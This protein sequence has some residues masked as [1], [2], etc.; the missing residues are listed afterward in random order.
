MGKLFRFLFGLVILA[1]LLV[2]LAGVFIYFYFDPN[3]YK[4]QIVDKVK[5]QTGRE[6]AINQDMSLLFFPSLAIRLADVELKQ[7]P[8]FGKGTFAKVDELSVS[9]KI[10]PLFSKQL[11]ID[12]II[13][14]GLELDL[15]K[16]KKGVTNWSDLSANKREKPPEAPKENTEKPAFALEKIEI[17]GLQLKNAQIHWDD[18]QQ[19]QKVDIQD[20]NLSLGQIIPNQIIPLEFKGKVQVNKPNIKT[21]L[22][23]QGDF[24]FN[25]EYTHF[26]LNNSVIQVNAKGDVIPAKK[27]ILDLNA[28]IDYDL[29]KALAKLAQIELKIATQGAK[30]IP[31]DALTI[32]LKT[33]SIQYDV[34]Q[35]SAK[36]PAFTLNID[37][38]KTNH[39][40]M[41]PFKKINWDIKGNSIQYQNQ[42]AIVKQLHAKLKADGIDQK[43]QQVDL[44]LKGNITWSGRHQSL[45]IP[46]L[47][48]LAK[49]NGDIVPQQKLEADLKTDLRFLVKPLKINLQKLAL[50]ANKHHIKGFMVVQPNAGPKLNFDL[51][52]DQINLDQYMPAKSDQPTTATTAPKTP[53]KANDDPLAPLRPLN[54]NGQL[55][56]G[57]LITQGVTVK[58]IQ[59]KV[60]AK[61]GNIQLTKMKAQAYEG[62]LVGSFGL[63]ARY[64]TPKIKINQKLTGIQIEPILKQFAKTDILEGKGN[65]N[66]N[67]T[68]KGLE[69]ELIQKTLNGTA[70]FVFNDGAV[71]GINLAANARNFESMLT[72]KKSNEVQKT[73]FA[74]LSGHF[75]I[76][77]GIVKNKDLNLMSQLVRVHGK[78]WVNLPKQRIKYLLQ[79]KLVQSLKGQGGMSFEKLPGV[80]VAIKLSGKLTDPKKEIRLGQALK[81]IANID[82][83]AEKKKLREQAKA[84][85]KELEDKMKAKLKDKLG[86]E[87]GGEVG[88]KLNKELGGAL[89]GL[90]G[91]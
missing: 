16:D 31:F 72:G 19:N 38:T 52:L 64:K 60:K 44:D 29:T 70:S 2:V 50:T 32:A 90:F 55:K 9:V 86:K 62:Q 42:K 54:I 21:E 61:K 67:L 78:G 23:L 82:L 49:V 10:I 27:I 57:Q 85:Q 8:Q 14:D 4:Q 26:T 74:E 20:L 76:H 83:D 66:L 34:N 18:Q 80:P 65:L 1:V 3:D 30:T 77:N 75:N 63:D 58:N 46:N 28:N 39:Q 91:G 17:S 41:P 24:T 11:E 48:V 87:L 51:S 88:D 22:A 68:M 12:T 73:D 15:R 35:T 56:I 37:A 89:K 40:T 69:P 47:A 7:A 6:L 13:L 25:S 53:A 79:A 84:K 5:Q 59:V 33:Q 43:I 81:Q 71:K 45:I 36:I